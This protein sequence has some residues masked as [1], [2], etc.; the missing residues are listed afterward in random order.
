MLGVALPIV[1][2]LSGSVPFGVLA[3]RA[4][5]VDVRAYGSGNIGATNVSRVLG[6]RLGLLV[7]G[8]DAVKGALPTLLAVG[9]EPEAPT[10]HVVVGLAAVLGHIFPLWLRFRGGKGVATALGV[11]LVLLPIPALC[12]ALVYAGVVALVRI[13]SL[14]S[15]LGAATAL[16]ASWYL[17]P[18][19]EYLYGVAALTALLVVTH[20]SNLRRLLRRSERRL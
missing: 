15:L 6:S 18:A 17:D 10:L 12:G 3:G 14:G 8:L 11:L 20:Q 7:L 1:A 9:L 13:S 2:Y 4:R 16:G 19:A 5:G